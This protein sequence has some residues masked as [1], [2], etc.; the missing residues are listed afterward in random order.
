MDYTIPMH[1][2]GRGLPSVMI[3]IRQDEIRTAAD[4][5][6]WAALIGRAFQRIESTAPRC[7]GG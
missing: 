1:G 6:D 5:A 4:A 2:G 3:E 7:I